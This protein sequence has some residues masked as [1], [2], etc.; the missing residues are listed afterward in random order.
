MT[1]VD[2]S[3]PIYGVRLPLHAAKLYLEVLGP[4]SCRIMERWDAEF[5]SLLISCFIKYCKLSCRCRMSRCAPATTAL[6]LKPD[7]ALLPLSTQHITESNTLVFGGSTPTSTGIDNWMIMGLFRYDAATWSLGIRRD[8]RRDYLGHTH[9]HAWAILRRLAPSAPGN[10]G[11][12]GCQIRGTSKTGHHS[13][14]RSDSTSDMPGKANGKA[15]R[16]AVAPLKLARCDWSATVQQTADVGMYSTATRPDS[17]L[18]AC[19]CAHHTDRFRGS[20]ICWRHS[21]KRHRSVAALWYGRARRCSAAEAWEPQVR[22][23]IMILI[24]VSMRL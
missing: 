11:G 14:Q 20:R 7:A 6:N 16:T 24:L 23:A 19:Q 3:T 1:Q 17:E 18:H 4:C 12:R 21:C 13:G 10:A 15:L 2:R 5:R 22:H 9:T 8:Y